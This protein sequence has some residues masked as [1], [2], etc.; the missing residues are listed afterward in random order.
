MVIS[1]AVVAEV[2]RESI[3]AH[4][5]MGTP[6]LHLPLW[7]MTIFVKVLQHLIIGMSPLLIVFFPVLL[8]G[9]VTFV[10]VVAAAV[11]S[12]ILH[13]SSRT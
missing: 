9:M 10:R 6:T 8:S 12:T 5:T 2:P 11:I 13:G 7:G 1:Q 4:V 3:N